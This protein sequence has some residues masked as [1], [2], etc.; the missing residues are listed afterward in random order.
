MDTH[1]YVIKASFNDYTDTV[2]TCA[3]IS[4]ADLM[5]IFGYDGAGQVG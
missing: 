3:V 2:H 4:L 5:Q 1:T